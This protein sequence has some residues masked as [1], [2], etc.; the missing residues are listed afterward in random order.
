MQVPRTQEKCQAERHKPVR[1]ASRE[2]ETRGPLELRGQAGRLSDLVSSR[3]CEELHL[4]KLGFEGK[5]NG[6]DS[7]RS[8][9]RK[10]VREPASQQCPLISTRAVRHDNLPHS[11][12]THEQRQQQCEKGRHKILTSG[13]T[14]TLVFLHTY[15]YSAAVKFMS[16]F[17]I[18]TAI[19][20]RPLVGLTG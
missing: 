20:P 16:K 8:V 12:H 1:L 18:P 10:G 19:L 5:H 2:T 3:F 14:C 6:H 11:S 9:P 4:K 13:L 15:L 17:T 7:L